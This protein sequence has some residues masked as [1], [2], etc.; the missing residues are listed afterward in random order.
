MKVSFAHLGRF[1]QTRPAL[2]SLGVAKSWNGRWP[3]RL[4]RAGSVARA[5]AP[6]MFLSGPVVPDVLRVVAGR[7]APS[8]VVVW[9]MTSPSADVRTLRTLHAEGLR[10][11][12]A[13][14]ACRRSV[15]RC[16]RR[17][18]T[19]WRLSVAEAPHRN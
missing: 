13:G 8:A 2:A 17:S 6:A 14:V 12:R 4:R 5:G 15:S 1:G 11:A 19:P 7:F 18:P 9:S 3:P 16:R 10:C